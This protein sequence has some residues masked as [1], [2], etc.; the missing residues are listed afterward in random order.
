LKKDGGL[1]FLATNTI[2]QGDTREVGLESLVDLDGVIYRAV[3]S[4][5]WPGS[6]NLEVAHLWIRQGIWPGQIF[7]D[8]DPAPGITAFLTV[9]MAVT[10]KPH[11]LA[12]NA[13]LA[14]TGN[15]VYGEG[16][17]LSVEDAQVLISKNARNR[18]VLYPYLS[19]DDLNSQPDQAPS[20]WV[21][22]FGERS[23][24]QSREYVECF[25]IVTRL[26][27]PYRETVK[28]EHTRRNWWLHEHIRPELYDTISCMKHALVCPIVTKYPSFVFSPTNIVFMHKVCIFAFDTMDRFAVLS[29]TIHEPWA[30]E[31]SCTLETR[32]NYSSTDCFDTFPFPSQKAELA[33]AGEAY[34]VARRQVMLSRQEGLTKSYNRF[35]DPSEASADIQKLRQ[36]HVE[37]DHAV[38]AAY[39]WTDLDLGHGFHQTKQ[40]LR[41][42]ISEAA[43]REVLARLL[44]LNHQRYAEEV[45]KGLHEKKPRNTRK[46]RKKKEEGGGMF[47]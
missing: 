17:V 30:R 1:G 9:P 18:E 11:R 28:R 15:K 7:L 31:Y 2:A 29:S 35:H 22:N 6:A 3:P 23:L 33:Q 36:L 24:D 43:R 40:G 21:I 26:V 20:R 37:M 12:A 41:Y 25:D 34:L 8:D 27:R 19:G 45:A 10:G 38:A 14:F 13:N 39:G 16:F 44:T 32:L 47:G 5:K 42:T 46:T 4:R